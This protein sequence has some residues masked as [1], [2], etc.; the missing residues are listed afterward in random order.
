MSTPQLNDW[1]NAG[2]AVVRTDYQGLG[3]PGP[4]PYLIGKS[5]GRVFSTSCARR[6]TRSPGSASGS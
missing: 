3:T 1:V 4:H 6:G 5:E 2:Y